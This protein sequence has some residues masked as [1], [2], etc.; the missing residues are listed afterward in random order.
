MMP[1]MRS[2]DL[3][4]VDR[5]MI[6]RNGDVVVAMHNGELTVKRLRKSGGETFLEAE[7]S[8]YPPLLCNEDTLIWGVVLI[9]LHWPSHH[10]R[11]S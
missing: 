3:L 1:L 5:A 9:N 7:N 10:A 2:G 4:V 8:A 6:P 11:N